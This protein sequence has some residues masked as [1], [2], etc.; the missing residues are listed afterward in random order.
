MPNWMPVELPHAL[1]ASSAT[2]GVIRM[3]DMAVSID[4]MSNDGTVLRCAFSDVCA[5]RFLK[6]VTLDD[7]ERTNHSG[8][9]ADHP[10]YVV[11]GAW[12]SENHPNRGKS[13]K[14]YR[15]L[16]SSASIDLISGKAPKFSVIEMVADKT[17]ATLDNSGKRPA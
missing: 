14:H 16:L 12:F 7:P 8:I 9:V 2:L 6:S 4:I 11:K 10:I 1:R 17:V 3:K 13:D 15:I 5:S